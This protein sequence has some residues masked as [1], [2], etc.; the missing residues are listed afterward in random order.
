VIGIGDI[1]SALLLLVIGV[2]LAVLLVVGVLLLIA[3][4]ARRRRSS[5]EGEP[6][7]GL[8]VAGLVLVG[9]AVGVP[10]A[11]FAVSSETGQP[12][13]LVFDLR[14][15]MR[16]GELYGDEMPGFQGFYNYHQGDT[17]LRLPGGRRATMTVKNSVATV[18]DGKVA[19]VSI[20]WIAEP[21]AQAAKRAIRWAHALDLG[22]AGASDAAD[23]STSDW[24]D[25]TNLKGMRATVSLQPVSDG[26]L[27]I[28]RVRIDLGAK[29][30]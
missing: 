22:A 2:V 29:G 9:I 24:S 23:D 28:P 14:D 21:P 1:G 19:S 16:E 26:E 27:M 7:R 11:G 5:G 12:D 13:P 30:A 8:L 3:H 15:G 20:S 6:R 18:T 4:A 10:I 25:T 17:E